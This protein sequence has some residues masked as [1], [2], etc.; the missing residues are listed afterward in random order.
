MAFRSS[1]YC[2]RKPGFE[3]MLREEA[4][5]S[6]HEQA[7]AN[8]EQRILVQAADGNLYSYL[9]KEYG[10]ESGGIIP[11]TSVLGHYRRYQF[12]ANE[13]SCGS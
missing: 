2:Y 11:L 13:G 8:G 9:A 1:K 10:A 4:A 3:Q 7:V 12:K 6:E 5:Q